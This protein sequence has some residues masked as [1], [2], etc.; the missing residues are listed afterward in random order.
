M[1]PFPKHPVLG[2]VDAAHT[3]L[4]GVLSDSVDLDDGALDELCGLCDDDCPDTVFDEPDEFTLLQAQNSF[5]RRAAFGINGAA[6]GVQTRGS[7]PVKSG[8]RP[9]KADET[10]SYNKPVGNVITRAD[11]AVS[12]LSMSSDGAGGDDCVRDAVV[13]AVRGQNDHQSSHSSILKHI[14]TDA[15]IEESSIAS[16]P[17]LVG[18]ELTGTVHRRLSD[19]TVRFMIGEESAKV[20]DAL[21]AMDSVAAQV[22]A[23]AECH[24]MTTDDE[25]PECLS[26]DWVDTEIEICLDSGCCEHVMD[27]GDAP[28]YSTFLTES[29]GSKR[30]QKFI[31]GNGA[32][33]PNEGQLLLNMESSTTTGVMKLQSC[34]QVAEVTRPLMS[35]SRVCDQ[36][37]DCWFNETEARVIDK[38]GKTLVSFQ[39]QGGLYISKMQLKPPEG[40]GGPPR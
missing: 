37:L 14:R 18:G 5:A 6:P 15:E 21:D 32:R 38:S 39:R 11:S 36:G 30:Q 10:T 29:P 16:E 8:S 24:V 33:V 12:G 1:F 9:S 26:M 31:V 22:R 4:Q 23:H 34:F 19:K 7:K 35:V 28:G 27:L 20:L 17:T 2:H 40:F 25:D 13:R 3:P